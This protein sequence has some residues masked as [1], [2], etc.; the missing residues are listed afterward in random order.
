MD[1]GLEVTSKVT[2]GPGILAPEVI[3]LVGHGKDQGGEVCQGDVDQV[4]V[5]S[6]PR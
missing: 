1:Y 6:S 4:H 5:C 2:K 3:E